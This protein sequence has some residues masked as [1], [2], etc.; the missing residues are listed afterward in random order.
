MDTETQ[1]PAQPP[2]RR[3]RPRNADRVPQHAAA[4]S[5]IERESEH[6]AEHEAPRKRTRQRSASVQ[7]NPFDAVNLDKIPSDITV[8][9]KRYSNVGADDPFYLSRMEEQGWLAVDPRQHPDWVPLP[10]GYDKPH[11]IKDGL[12]LMERPKELTDEARKENYDLA[13]RQI[14]EAEQRLGKTPKDTMTREEEGV[15]PRVVKEVGR[16]IVE[17]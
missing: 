2:V 9:W 7:V 14:R 4:P 3:G 6:V 16:M 5:P 8:E 12:I 15:R 11:I 10:P 13:N 17:E 1:Q